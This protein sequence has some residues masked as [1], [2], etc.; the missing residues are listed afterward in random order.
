[1]KQNAQLASGTTP[2]AAGPATYER[3]CYHG[4]PA[5]LIEL[6]GR[7]ENKYPDRAAYKRIIVDASK[8]LAA[9]LQD[10]AILIAANNLTPAMP[11][12]SAEPAQMTYTFLHP[13]LD[14]R[15]IRFT[16]LPRREERS[17]R[18]SREAPD[19]VRAADPGQM[20][21][22]WRQCLCSRRPQPRRSRTMVRL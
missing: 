9:W 6:E 12:E 14:Q 3:G 19:A 18:N 8:P 11:T 21:S 16:R 20:D 10:N 15:I 1:M 5:D 4:T 13:G 17:R 2:A 22:S 7:A